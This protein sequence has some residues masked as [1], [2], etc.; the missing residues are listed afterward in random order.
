MD[1]D[2][3]NQIDERFLD[4]ASEY[5]IGSEDIKIKAL[6]KTAEFGHYQGQLNRVSGNTIGYISEIVISNYSMPDYKTAL[7]N[8]EYNAKHRGSNN[9][10]PL[11][12][13]DHEYAHA[14]DSVYAI[15]KSP[16][17]NASIQKWIGKEVQSIG[18]VYEI[19]R[20]NQELACSD[21]R[22]SQD[23]KEQLKADYSLSE[24]DFLKTVKKELGSYATTNTREFL[25]EGFS[26]Y[27]H[28]PAAEQSEF[29]KKFGERFEEL[30]NEV[31]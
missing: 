30:F 18:D 24:E 27:R 22:L 11:S 29:L 2:F 9:T 31:F 25:A 1:P 23:L 3:A 7:R 13:V 12:T 28:I 26:A 8:H 10:S 15:K 5:P 16:S 20:I 14:I 21:N 4:L 19:N 6:K 17:L